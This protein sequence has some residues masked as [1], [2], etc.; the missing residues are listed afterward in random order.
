MIS[1][2]RRSLPNHELEDTL[3]SRFFSVRALLEKHWQEHGL[4]MVII[5]F[6][7]QSHVSIHFKVDRLTDKH[8][9]MAWF[10]GPRLCNI[11]KS[12]SLSRT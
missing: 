11:S 5:L 12:E 8:A 1:L 6:N 2:V 3:I 10:V 9:I 7:T 4:A